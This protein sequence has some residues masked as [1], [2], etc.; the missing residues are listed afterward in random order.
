MLDHAADESTRIHETNQLFLG[1][2]DL[3]DLFD[4]PN[5]ELEVVFIDVFFGNLQVSWLQETEDEKLL[6]HEEVLFLVLGQ[7]EDFRPNHFD[8]QRLQLIES[9]GSVFGGFL[10]VDFHDVLLAPPEEIDDVRGRGVP[11]LVEGVRK[12]H[13]ENL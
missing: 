9:G 12:L 10:G 7:F 5:D 3:L 13:N 4:L 6:L 8:D 11:V 1:S 2:V